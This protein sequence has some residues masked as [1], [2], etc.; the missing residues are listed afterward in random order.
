[1]R[2]LVKTFFRHGLMAAG[3]GPVVLAIVYACLAQAGVFEKLTAAEVVKG[4]LTVT[5]LAF[6]AGGVPVVYQI[7]RLSLLWA[8]LIHAVVLYADYILIYLL[9]GWLERGWV[10]IL[11]FT[12]CFFTGYA[13]I[14]LC[15]FQRVR[16]KVARV[17]QSMGWQ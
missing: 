9:N 11:V 4:I 8:T 14:W 1:M 12:V 6:I 17:N 16:A 15:I 2:G 5:L 3:G 10:P 13:L 7:E